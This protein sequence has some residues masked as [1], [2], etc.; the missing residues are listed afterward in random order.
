MNQGK[1]I[2]AQL[3]EFA[4]HDA[5]R[6]SVDKYNGNYKAKDFTCWKQFLCLA[7]GQLTHRESMYRPEKSLHFL[8]N[9]PVTSLHIFFNPVY[10]L[11]LTNWMKRKR[12]LLRSNSPGLIQ[13]D[14]H[15]NPL[16]SLHLLADF[17]FLCVSAMPK[18]TYSIIS[19]SFLF[20]LI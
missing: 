8:V 14:K 6:R 10:H 16:M 20:L 17:T 12:A 1:M 5:F 11:H 18:K 9:N 7:F 3:M 4:S 2:F 19:S 15:I 13:S